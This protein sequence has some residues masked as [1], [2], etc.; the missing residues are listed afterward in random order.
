[1]RTCAI[2]QPTYLPWLGF[3]E[4]IAKSDVFVIYDCV[5]FEKQSWQQRNKVRAKDGTI[6]L[7]LPVKYGTG[8]LRTIKEVEIDYS[9]QVPKKH[10][11]TL[12]L[13]YG[14]SVGFS[15]I[16]PEIQAI[17]QSQP[18]LLMDMNLLLIKTG[19]KYFGIDTPFVFASELD[20]QGNRVEALIDICKKVNAD[21]Y[22]SPVGSKVY[23]EENNLF[24]ENNI[25]LSY[26][27]YQHPIYPQLN[28]TDFISHLSFIDYLFNQENY[29]IIKN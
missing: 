28:Y 10:L 12:Q 23:I 20:V 8:L 27:N 24:A 26:Q 18:K 29:N 4:L 7:T 22:F 15:T 17:Y 9:R 25:Q 19:M 2:M 21:H 13:S 14:K 16:F 6:M 5:Q 3:F 1:M 11:N